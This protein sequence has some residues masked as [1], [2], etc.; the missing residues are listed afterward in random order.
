MA[1]FSDRIGIT[2]PVETFQIDG[3]SV[4]LRNALWNWLYIHLEDANDWHRA[5][6]DL[7]T[8]FWKGRR[9]EVPRLPSDCMEEIKHHFFDAEW[10][11]V[12]NLLEYALEAHRVIKWRGGSPPAALPEASLNF[13]LERERSGF[14]AAKGTLV[15]ITNAQELR[16]I[17]QGGT[18]KPMFEGSALHIRTAAEM[19]SRKPKPDYRNSIKESISAVESVAKVL[20]GEKSGGID[21]AI[22]LLEKSGRL[23]PAFKGA[24]S[25]LYGYTSDEDGI[26]HPILEQSTTTFAEAKFM[27]VACSAF[28]NFLI[29]TTRASSS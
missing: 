22:R 12:Y 5:A 8:N 10:W 6:V 24:L 26:R 20:T 2:R 17:D 4:E 14:R 9:D 16:A 28:V 25:K 15:P 23:H 7:L 18:P 21:S 27:L 11:Q 19:L 1:K 13:Y 3:M 29:D